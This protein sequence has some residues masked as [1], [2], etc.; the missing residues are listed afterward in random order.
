MVT[1][2]TEYFKKQIKSLK[3]RYPNVIEDF[4]KTCDVFDQKKEISIGKSI[5]KMRIPSRDQKRGKSG[6][7]RSYLYLYRKND[8]LVPICIYAKSKQESL[9][10]G[11]LQYH[12]DHIN[13]ELLKSHFF[14][15]I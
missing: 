11:E 4:I 5:Y 1:Y 8:M 14:K 3:K 2:L 7:F 15:D 10:E 6:G 13:E 9:P 12:L